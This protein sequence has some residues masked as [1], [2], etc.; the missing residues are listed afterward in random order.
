MNK[1]KYLIIVFSLIKT[2]NV[3]SCINEY[4]TLLSGEVV[5]IDAE[6]LLPQA[7]FSDKT[8]LLKELGEL[9]K[10]YNKTKKIEDYSDLGS[11]YVYLGNYNKAKLIFKEI[12][13]NLQVNIKLL[14]I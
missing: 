7:K 13:K 11:M 5:Y 3:Q 4:R 6:D 12:E 10:L 9:E 1:I 2:I 14:R 8:S